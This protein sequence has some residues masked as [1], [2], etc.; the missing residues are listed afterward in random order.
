MQ[1]Y[2]RDWLDNYLF[3]N[4]ATMKA[5]LVDLASVSNKSYM[6]LCHKAVELRRQGHT[7]SQIKNTLNWIYRHDNIKR[8]KEH[9]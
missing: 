2:Q 4:V 3:F 7:D 8:I 6:D 1:N 5:F 9:D